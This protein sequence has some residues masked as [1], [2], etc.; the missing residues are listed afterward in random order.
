MRKSFIVSLVFIAFALCTNAQSVGGVPIFDT[1]TSAIHPQACNETYLVGYPNDSTWVNL[2]PG[3]VM[4]G[5][6]STGHLVS[7]GRDLLL[8]T[9]FN[10]DNYAVS[11]LLS[12]GAYSDTHYVNTQ[13]WN[14]LPNVFWA[15]SGTNCNNSYSSSLHWMC[16]LDFNGHF[17]LS[18][19]D[20]VTGIS[21][22]FLSTSGEP[23]IAGIYIVED[24][25]CGPPQLTEMY[26][27]TICDG[28]SFTVYGMSFNQEGFY[29]ESVLNQFGC[30]SIRF[31]VSLE[32]EDVVNTSY[33]PT[34]CF[35]DS[36]EVYGETYTQQ[37]IY[38]DTIV[39]SNGCD[40]IRYSVN[41]SVVGDSLITENYSLRICEGDSVSLYGIDYWQEGAYSDTLFNSLGCDSL[42]YALDLVVDSSQLLSYTTQ[43]CEGS[44]FDVH[45][46]SYAQTGIYRDTLFNQ[47]GCDSINIEVNLDVVNAQDVNFAPILCWGD[48]FEVYGTTYTQAGIYRDTIFSASGCDSIRTLVDLTYVSEAV[49]S[50]DYQV[51]ICEGEDYN[52]HGFIYNQTGIYED[53]LL[54][55]A[56]CDSIRFR[57]EL[58]V[59]EV[60]IESY[61]EE[62]CAGEM[63]QI[64]GNSYTQTGQYID[65]ILGNMGCD[66]IRFTLNL[67]VNPQYSVN[68]DTLICEGQSIALGADIL[69]A[70]GVY[71]SSLNSVSGC[72]SV[73]TISLSVDTP[74]L[75]NALRDT[76][77]CIGDSLSLDVETIGA[78]AYNWSHGE[79]TPALTIDEAG[80]YIVTITFESNC[81][82]FDTLNLHTIDCFEHCPL[83]FPT[84]FSPNASGVNDD[85]G[86]LNPCQL[87]FD[88][89][90]LKIFNRWGE[91][92]FFSQDENKAWPGTHGTR[93]APVGVYVYQLIYQ[94]S[95]EDAEEKLTG[96]I[97][98]IR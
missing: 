46:F 15:Y 63:V 20:I 4:T 80:E 67:T 71:T 58:D 47:W 53:T 26:S 83:I 16:L 9:S 56:G 96:N 50:E 59:M 28:D 65:T 7:T 10:R 21:V 91:L 51:S 27:P 93:P 6:F 54:N 68:L 89:F 8:E 25:I 2:F 75:S 36:F 40:S 33:S 23:D 60:E 97:T 45:G 88:R 35:G 14:L 76:S 62:I 95:G 12:T 77:I 82:L 13:D 52:I 92:V 87:E 38:Y 90:D 39:G 18:A 86:I 11:L 31:H 74:Q 17:G 44:T 34:I 41:L 61:S 30:D 85:F 57:L 1:L 70:S 42:I 84:G 73:V 29:S 43:I 5:T 78:N 37:G 69:N 55:H 22:T 64:H 66:S 49:L 24:T 72:D 3:D 98:L 32:I 81:Q 48:S 19:S 79:I 94:L